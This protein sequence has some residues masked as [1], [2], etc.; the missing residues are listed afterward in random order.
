MEL[1]KVLTKTFNPFLGVEEGMFEEGEL[2]DGEELK[3]LLKWG[4][5]V[6]GNSLELGVFSGAKRFI[7]SPLVQEVVKAIY[8][9][10][11][12]YSPP[13]AHSLILDNYKTKPIVTLYDWTTSPL[14]DYNRLRVPRIRNRLEFFSFATLLGLFLISQLDHDLERINLWEG[15]FILW[16]LG[17]SFDEFASVKENGLTTYLMGIYNAMDSMFCLVFL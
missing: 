3:R 15:L 16:S 12:I 14:L 17:F 9:G 7:R 8:D 2:R 11:V 1:L 13:A 6:E 10:T 4:K 5:E